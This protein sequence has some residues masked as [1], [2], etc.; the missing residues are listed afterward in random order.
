MFGVSIPC[1]ESR[2][3]RAMFRARMNKLHE[4]ERIVV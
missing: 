2:R 4:A 1:P 3:V